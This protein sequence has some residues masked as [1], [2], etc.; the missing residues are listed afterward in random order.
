MCILRARVQVVVER[1]PNVC[2]GL[3]LLPSVNKQQQQKTVCFFP[4]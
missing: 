2:E 3:G 4:P 1:L